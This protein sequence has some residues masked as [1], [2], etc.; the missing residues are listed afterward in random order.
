MIVHE[1]APVLPSLGVKGFISPSHFTLVL[2]SFFVRLWVTEVT[3][4]NLLSYFVYFYLN[5]E[6]RDET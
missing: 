2:G 1:C 6:H 4:P 3:S 5:E